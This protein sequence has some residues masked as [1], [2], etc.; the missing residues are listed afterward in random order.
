MFKKSLIKIKCLIFVFKHVSTTIILNYLIESTLKLLDQYYWNQS[1]MRYIKT[2]EFGTK[3]NA[4][5]LNLD[6]CVEKNVYL[7]CL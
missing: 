5:L 6:K 2:A 4:T 1:L 3:F 7:T